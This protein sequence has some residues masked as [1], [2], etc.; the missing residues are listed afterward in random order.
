MVDINRGYG[1]G[2]QIMNT[3]SFDPQDVGIVA[4]L[5][6]A[7]RTGFGD[8]VVAVD[9]GANIGV[10][11]VEWAKYIHGWGR[12]IGF[13]AQ[14]RIYYSLAGDIAINNCLNVMGRWAAV[15]FES[16]QIRIP[17]PDHHVPSSFGSLELKKGGEK[18]VHRSADRLFGR[19]HASHRAEE[20]RFPLT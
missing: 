2:Y 5:L 9:C 4:A 8:G 15:G 17:V 12:V 13:E 20:H 10:K 3:G 18:R 11:T 1:V 14:E 16:K 19:H 6:T 7:R